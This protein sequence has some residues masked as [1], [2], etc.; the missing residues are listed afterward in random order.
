MGLANRTLQYANLARK[1][2]AAKFSKRPWPIS[3][4]YN[5]TRFCNLRCS[6]C[7]AML[8]QLDQ[9]DASLEQVLEVVD[10][11]HKGGTLSIRLLGGEPL[12]RKD[13]PK[14]I[15]RI[16]AHGMFCEVVTNGTLLR[17]RIAQWPELAMVDSFSVSLDGDPTLHDQ[18]RGAGVFEQTMDGIFALREAGYPVRLHATL[19]NDSYDAHIPPHHFLAQLSQEYGIPF[20][21]A[22]YA[23]NPGKNSREDEGNRRSFQRAIQVYK[24][25]LDYHKQGVL[26]TTDRNILKKSIEWFDHTDKFRLFGDRSVIP[27]GYRKCQAGFRNCF[28]DSDG[29]M[30]TCPAHWKRGVSVYRE[31]LAKAV[32][33]LCATR[34]KLG[35]QICYNVSQWEYT[36]LF[37]FSDP[38]VLLN[39][40]RNIARLIL[41]RKRGRRL[42]RTAVPQM[43][44]SVNGAFATIPPASEDARRAVQASATMQTC[45]FDGGA[46]RTNS[47]PAEAVS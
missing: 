34:Q 45:Q 28:I 41:Q 29:G 44:L 15:N 20:N 13:L 9:P 43:P 32:E 2:L 40:A 6:H 36:R 21:I 47:D 19:A 8:E 1:L 42:Q 11:L 10:G 35:C 25:L 3:V 31:G 14:V 39:T 27:K 23:P 33:V 38:R 4:S 5:V 17:Q 18:I 7:Y 26:V 37:T 16:K 46:V 12:V 30:Y 24:D 22:T